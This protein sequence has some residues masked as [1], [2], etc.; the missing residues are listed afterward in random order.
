MDQE[1]LHSAI[2]EALADNNAYLVDLV[3][4]EGN[5]IT[6]FADADEGIKVHQLKMINRQI[7]DAFDREV[8]DFDLTVSSP[9]L[10]RPFKVKRQFANSI[11]RWVKVKLNEGE[12]VI[13]KLI[14]V[15]DENIT[16][17]IPA[18]K[19]NQPDTEKTF[20]FDEINE[21]KIE[22]RF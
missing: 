3:L 17:S 14:S 12:K 4:E 9:G 1:K 6:L 16:V 19:K 18:E 2:S 20:A 5:K 11:G 15:T 22:I 8:E 21:T 13:G 10:D 7:E